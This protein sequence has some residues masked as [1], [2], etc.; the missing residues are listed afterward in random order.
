MA[1]TSTIYNLILQAFSLVQASVRVHLI[2][3]FQL[4]DKAILYHSISFVKGA[5]GRGTI[6]RWT[7]GTAD[8]RMGGGGRQTTGNHALASFNT[9]R[10]FVQSK[11]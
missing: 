2:C 3:K 4:D 6:H 7:V 11:L 8:G 1:H 10:D 5:N 9:P